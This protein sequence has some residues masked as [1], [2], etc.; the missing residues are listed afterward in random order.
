MSAP[1]AKLS[2]GV[3]R[4]DRRGHA[5]VLGPVLIDMIGIGLI[6]PVAPDLIREVT[7]TDLSTASTL[8]GLLFVAYSA[9]Q[10]LF[11]PVIG[12]LSDAYGRRPVLLVSVLGLGLDY[13]V[14]LDLG[15]FVEQ[16]VRECGFLPRGLAHPAIFSVSAAA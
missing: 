13:A 9:M 3:R 10:F 4:A 8:G 16:I 11:G 5:F 7:G 2:I 12:N 6:V 15:L 1:P 14:A